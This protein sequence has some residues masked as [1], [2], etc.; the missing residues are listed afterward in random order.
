NR[1]LAANPDK[2]REELA[3]RHN[4]YLEPGSPEMQAWVQRM[5]MDNVFATFAHPNSLAGYLALLLPAFIGVPFACSR[6][7]QPTWH[8][9][10]V[11]ACVLTV[12]VGLGFTHSRGALYAPLLVAAAVLALRWRTLPFRLAAGLLAG[13]VVLA[14]VIYLGLRLGPGKVVAGQSLGLRLDYLAAAWEMIGGQPR[15]GLR[16]GHF[17]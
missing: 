2:L 14:V 17:R 16:S 9:L 6:T 11:A 12:A 8:L 1:E 15:L 4:V 7:A 3:T 5:Q 13:W 10:L